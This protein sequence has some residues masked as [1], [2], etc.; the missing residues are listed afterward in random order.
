MTQT[1]NRGCYYCLETFNESEIE[2]YVD[3]GNTAL[4]P[5]CMVDAVTDKISKLKELQTQYFGGGE[6]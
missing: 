4:C 3:N 5:Y 6:Q 2:D 1:N